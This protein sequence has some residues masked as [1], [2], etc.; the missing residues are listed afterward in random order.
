MQDEEKSKEQLINELH[1]MRQRLAAFQSS[2]MNHKTTEY[3]LRISEERYKKMVDAVTAYIYT[4]IID[5][6][7][8]VST[9]HSA[10]CIFVTGYRPEDYESNPMLWYTMIH[11]DDRQMVEHSINALLHGSSISPV[12]HRIIRRDGAV[13]WIRNTIA[14][15]YDERGVL[16]RYDGLI[17]DITDRKHAE[18]VLRESEKKFRAVAQ[19]AVDAIIL[20]DANGNIM[21]W[22]ESARKIF[23]YAEQEILGKPLTL[24]MPERYRKD[25][26]EGLER[27]KSTGQSEYIGKITEMSGLRKTGDSFP[28]ELSVA[29]WRVEKETFF[30]GIVRDITKRKQLESE[31]HILATTDSLTHVFNRIKYNELIK[32][33]IERS[34]RYDHPLSLIMFDI[35]HFKKVNDTYGHMVGDSVLCTLSQ[36]VKINLR[37]TDFLVRWGGEEFVIIAPETDLPK[38]VNLA[39]RIRKATE[40]YQFDQAGRITVSFGVAEF[41]KDDTEDVLIKKADDAMYMAK[42]KGKNRVEISI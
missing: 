10:G 33:E 4:V 7:Q 40:D 5:A 35:D 30:S 34:R 15:Y 37:E 38:A 23:G 32:R 28:I 29:M 19:T 12:E 36:L 2:A 22:N 21:F 31:M 14:P 18:E 27:I 6:G 1:E 24:M 9:R 13:V 16:F 20:A 11:P 3:D 25:H 26:Q 8:A 41:H 39:E 17:E 42:K